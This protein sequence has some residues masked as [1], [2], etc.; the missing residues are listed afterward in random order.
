MVMPEEGCLQAGRVSTP[1]R[2]RKRLAPA[3]RVPQIL[4]AAVEEFTERGYGGARMAAVAD[5]ARVAKGLIYHYFPSKESLFR[6]VVRSCTQP[7]FEEAERRVAQPA[8][9]AR[10]TLSDLVTLGYGRACGD[11]RERALFRLILT[12]AERFPELSAFYR[13]EVF[14]RAVALVRA[15]L[16][17]GAET[18]EFRPEVAEMPGM[19]EV[20]LSPMVTAGVW[21]MIMGEGDAPVARMPLAHLELVLAGLTDRR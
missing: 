2:G 21:I 3:E 14:G 8:G 13:D 11:A 7:V 1:L 18:G 5:R 12:E 20:V 6:A 9:S 15:V 10:Q 17:A 4:D 19:A 16:R